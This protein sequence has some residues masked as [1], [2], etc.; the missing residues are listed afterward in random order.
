MPLRL[1]K[2]LLCSLFLFATLLTLSRSQNDDFRHC[3]DGTGV[4]LRCEP[5]ARSFSFGRPPQVNSTCGDP[6]ELFC[7]VTSSLG[8]F[9]NTCGFVCNASDPA[10][11][12]PP[13][14]MTDF[15]PQTTPTW[16][17]SRNGI[18]SP[19]T[20]VLNFTLDALVQ[21]QAIV[22]QFQSL[23]PH[24]F[25]ILK[26]VDNG[27]TYQPY[28]YFS[29]DCL[30]RY[31]ISHEVDLTVDN[32]T[33]V[34]C[35]VILNPAPG[36]ISFVPTVDR[37]SANDSIPG[38]SDALY[39]FITATDIVVVLDGHAIQDGLDNSSYHYAIRDINV[40]GKCACNGHAS[41][42]RS[43]SALAC[44]CEHNTTGSSCDRCKDTHNDVPWKITNGDGPFEC[45]GKIYIIVTHC[46]Y[47]DV[48]S[49]ACQCNGHASQCVF[50]QE[51][52]M[53]SGQ[54]SGGRCIN[55]SDNTIGAHCDSCAQLYYPQPGVP[56][57]STDYCQRKQIL[58]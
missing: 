48:F 27:Q 26:S 2:S 12:H 21:V 32:E 50:D 10:N 25:Y 29:K 54:T 53:E 6:P 18:Y 44:V 4:P 43:N 24:S 31:M 23:K 1:R 41:D 20:V 22:F 49:T 5:A 28:H 34:L 52:Y 8:Q 47:Y 40:I 56:I 19:E 42:C 51:L 35:Q 13:S 37:P 33:E 16:W 45:K 55:C 14:L 36:Q 30:S 39:Q 58:S 9:D 46:C 15:Y 17:Q 7:E 3:Y 11:A 38:L 57:N